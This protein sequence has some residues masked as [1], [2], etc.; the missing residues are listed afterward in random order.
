MIAAAEYRK[1]SQQAL[2]RGNVNLAVAYLESALRQDPADREC[3][4]A[5][6]R[7]LRLTGR[8]ERAIAWY[9]ACLRRYPG[10]SI[11]KMGLAALGQ[12][13]P[14]DRLPDD[15]V[16]YLFDRNAGAYEFSMEELAYCI[17]ETLL[18]M[19][20]AEKGPARG[21]LD[22]LDL[23]C[24][25]GLCG[26]LLRPFSRRLVG[27]DLSPEMLK[28][29]R[30]K[31]TYDE[32]I[33]GEILGSLASQEAGSVD[34]VVAASVVLYFGALEPFAEAV[35]RVL[36]PTGTFVFDVEEGVG[37]KA[38]FHAAGRF[39]HG[40]ELIEQVFAAPLFSGLRVSEVVMPGEAGKPVGALCC[41]A[42]R[43]SI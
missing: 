2:A 37:M 38:A 23:G 5:V 22:V 32:L 9:R 21:D 14:P 29:A 19:L 42:I 26:S 25:S 15:V 34:A 27:I 12:E 33:E 40:R 17:P 18:P 24:G 36:R 13:P 35:A 39:T 30:A 16:L 8:S 1:H 28:L 7:L 3:Y 11:A 41:A 31:D 20:A 10:D 43:S 4:H 6:G